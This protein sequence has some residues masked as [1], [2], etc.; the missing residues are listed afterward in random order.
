MQKQIRQARQRFAA[1][2]DTTKECGKANRKPSV[3]IHEQSNSRSYERTF[4]IAAAGSL[5]VSRREGPRGGALHYSFLYGVAGKYTRDHSPGQ[6]VGR[7][8]QNVGQSGQYVGRS[9]QDASNSGQDVGRSG[10]DTRYHLG[11]DWAYIRP[12]SGQHPANIPHNLKMNIVS[13]V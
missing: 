12:T 3:C 6:D 7:T 4:I 9:G 1:A 5:R 11:L 8:G 2:C 13:I 10:Q